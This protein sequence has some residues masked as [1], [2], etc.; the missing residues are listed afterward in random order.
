MAGIISLLEREMQAS[1]QD[2]H[3]DSDSEITLEDVNLLF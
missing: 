3:K 1:I 2:I